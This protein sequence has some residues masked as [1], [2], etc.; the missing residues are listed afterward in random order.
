MNRVR[1][2]LLPGILIIS[3]LIRVAVALYLGDV[4]DAPSLLTDQRSY[5][6]LAAR[7]ISGHG[8]SFDKPWY[9]FTPADTPTAHWSFLYSLTV[10]AVYAVF[11]VHPL[12]MRLAQ[13]IVGGVLL[14]LAVYQLA[15]R[16]FGSTESGE[17]ADHVQRD[18]APELVPL[19]AAAITAVYGYFALYAAT[20]M[21]ETL[22][23]VV[24][25][26]VT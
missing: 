21:T 24:R 14:P 8:F 16:V 11:G 6:A 4:V 9:P 25:G 15:H 13:A 23:I 17:P 3:V 19:A 5:H 20:L 10:A 22:F 12:A 1:R 18:R 26:L 7:L 2:W